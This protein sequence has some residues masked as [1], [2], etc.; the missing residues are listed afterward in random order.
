MKI[1]YYQ[2]SANFRASAELLRIKGIDVRKHQLSA[3]EIAEYLI[4]TK[5]GITDI[6]RDPIGDKAIARALF[7]KA[8]EEIGESVDIILLIS[9]LVE[10]SNLNESEISLRSNKQ[11]KKG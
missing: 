10:R 1:K 2:P 8:L 11:A 9:G 5:I 7:N 3:L 6:V 4:N